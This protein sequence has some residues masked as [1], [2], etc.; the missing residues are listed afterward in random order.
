MAS[1]LSGF[2]DRPLRLSQCCTAVKQSDSV[3]TTWCVHGLIQGTPTRS[4]TLYTAVFTA[5]Y[6]AAHGRVQTVYTAVHGPRTWSVRDPITAVYAAR[7]RP[8]TV[9][10]AVFTAHVHGIV[11]TVYMA[12]HEVYGPGTPA[13]KGRVHGASTAVYRVHL[14][15]RVPCTR[16]CLPPVYTA[17]HGHVHG[18][19]VTRSRPCTRP[20]HAPCTVNTADFT[21]RVHGIVPTVYTAVHDVYGPCTPA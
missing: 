5:V 19:S 2:I 15:G 20:V 12:V 13:C 9:N 11:R 14:H 6:K 10:T 4:C 18:P 1:V 21:A 8:C 17:A 16:P 7:T 3:E